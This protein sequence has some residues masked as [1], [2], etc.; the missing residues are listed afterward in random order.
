MVASA[1]T[2]VRNKFHSQL[3]CFLSFQLKDENKLTKSS[4][5]V[6]GGANQV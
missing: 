6:T 5:M 2:N 4:V 3:E 1:I